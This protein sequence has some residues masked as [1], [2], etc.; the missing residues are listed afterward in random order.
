MKSQFHVDLEQQIVFSAYSG[1]ITVDDVIAKTEAMLAD[2]N[3]RPGMGAVCDYSNATVEWS[4]AEVDRFRVFMSKITAKAGQSKWAI[5]FPKGKD[6]TTARIFVALHSAFVNGIEIQ[7]FRDQHSALN[8]VKEKPA[9]ADE[10]PNSKA[11]Q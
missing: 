10:V 7:I 2:P 9:A 8:W 4:L 5:I 3:Y 1:S 11:G 6:T